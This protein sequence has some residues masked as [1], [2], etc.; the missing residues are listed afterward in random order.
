MSRSNS[1]G[2]TITSPKTKRGGGGLKKILICK[3]FWYL[4]LVDRPSPTGR[5]QER[6][7]DS[8]LGSTMVALIVDTD[9]RMG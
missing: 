9:S 5:G 3:S 4:Y 1:I 7:F 6:I 8:C 2:K